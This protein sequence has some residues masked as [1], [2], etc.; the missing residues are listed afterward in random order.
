[1]FGAKDLS[2]LPNINVMQTA[3]PEIL[4][5]IKDGKFSQIGN[6][7]IQG[8]YDPKTGKIFMFADAIPQGQERGDL[9]DGHPPPV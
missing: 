9:P 1:M 5:K 2:G 4:S 3:T 7:T 8:A 6:E